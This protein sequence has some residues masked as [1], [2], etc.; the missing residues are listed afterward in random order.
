MPI[1]DGSS[2]KKRKDIETDLELD[3]ERNLIILNLFNLEFSGSADMTVN[4]V[5]EKFTIEAEFKIARIELAFTTST[6]S[7]GNVV[8]QVEV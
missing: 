7:E 2:P 3:A 6:T 8:P 1:N 5:K 4:D